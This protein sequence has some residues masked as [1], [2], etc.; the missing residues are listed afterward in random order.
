MLYL[1]RFLINFDEKAYSVAKRLLLRKI[2]QFCI[3]LVIFYAA[4]IIIYESQYYNG[5][6][7]IIPHCFN[8]LI[9]NFVLIQFVI[10]LMFINHFFQIIIDCFRKIL[11]PSSKIV[12]ENSVDFCRMHNCYFALSELANEVA[13]FY[14][15]LLLLFIV[16]IFI[17][18]LNCLHDLLRFF[19]IGTLSSVKFLMIASKFFFT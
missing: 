3:T 10:I 6:L 1:Q 2:T 14:C 18:L 13:E 7:Q 9:M 5:M 15:F 17:T 19:F 8:E 11:I 16:T 12:V 4:N